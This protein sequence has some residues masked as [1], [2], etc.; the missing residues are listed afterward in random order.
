MGLME[1]TE[2]M[3]YEEVDEKIKGEVKKVL[4]KSVVPKIISKVITKANILEGEILVDEVKRV[5][6][7]PLTKTGWLSS[8]L[9]RA[10]GAT[11]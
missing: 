8:Q 6:E 1:E 2:E 10:I 11:H 4:L 7:H 9:A 5:A 3:I